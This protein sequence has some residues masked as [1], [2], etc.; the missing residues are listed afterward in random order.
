MQQ[1]IMRITVFDQENCQAKA[2]ALTMTTTTEIVKLNAE[3]V[4]A[5]NLRVL[6]EANIKEN[7]DRCDSQFTMIN[8]CSDKLEKQLT[9]RC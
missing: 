7:Q 5:N 6:L 8:D 2:T 3:L 1:S 4:V 9:K